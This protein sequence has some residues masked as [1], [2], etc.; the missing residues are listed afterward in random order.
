MQSVYIFCIT[1]AIVIVSVSA[2][3]LI[4]Q[5]M[6][7][8]Q[9]ARAVHVHEQ[10]FHMNGA[11]CADPWNCNQYHVS[12]AQ[13]EVGHSIPMSKTRTLKFLNDWRTRLLKDHQSMRVMPPEQFGQLM[14]LNTLIYW[15]ET[16]TEWR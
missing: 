12:R 1:V 7:R 2:I 8:R 14:T 6:R 13:L 15:I 3:N 10:L 4:N 5:W 11:R 16:D 9:R